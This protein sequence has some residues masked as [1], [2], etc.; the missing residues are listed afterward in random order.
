MDTPDERLQL[1]NES[2]DSRVN[3]KTGT[4]PGSDIDFRFY[5]QQQQQHNQRD[6]R[7]LLHRSNYEFYGGGGGEDGGVYRPGPL[8]LRRETVSRSSYGNIGSDVENKLGL[9]DGGYASQQSHQAPS[10]FYLSNETGHTVQRR[11]A[12]DCDDNTNVR[13]TSD[14]FPL[15]G[16]NEQRSNLESRLSYS[17]L[18]RHPSQLHSPEGSYSGVEF[19]NP[20]YCVVSQNIEQHKTPKTV[21]KHHFAPELTQSHAQHTPVI[22]PWMKKLHI[23]SG[24]YS[25]PNRL[26]EL[27]FHG[28]IMVGVLKSPDFFWGGGV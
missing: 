10:N 2:C 9:Y 6:G 13:P 12:Y 16:P 20:V 11:F 17:S 4:Q 3:S 19:R 23:G 18:N 22:Y 8:S 15:S 14:D 24:N 26:Y 5:S 27:D 25:L 28:A 21:T 7:E 1:S